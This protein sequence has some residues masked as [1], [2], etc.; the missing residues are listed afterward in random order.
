[1][2]RRNLFDVAHLPCNLMLEHVP[3]CGRSPDHVLVFP[4]VWREGGTVRP[5]TIPYFERII[6]GGLLLIASNGTQLVS[7]SDG[8]ESSGS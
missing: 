5:K 3:Y 2:S 6:F 8:R 1:M 4:Q 7:N